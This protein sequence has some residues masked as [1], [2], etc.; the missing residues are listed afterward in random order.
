MG[1]E[2]AKEEAEVYRKGDKWND[3]LQ[4]IRDKLDY[5]GFVQLKR[6]MQ[7]NYVAACNAVEQYTKIEADEVERFLPWLPAAWEI[8][9]AAAKQT[10]EV[11][12]SSLARRTTMRKK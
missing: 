7:P 10:M 11:D 12:S 8:A 1:E 5:S 9:V 2:W 6:G 3:K 4:S